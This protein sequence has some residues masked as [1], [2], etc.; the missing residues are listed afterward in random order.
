MSPG[1]DPSGR[2]QRVAAGEMVLP[3]QC[4]VC[5]K[6]YQ[7]E[8]FVDTKLDYDFYGVVYFCADCAFELTT[9]FPE[10]PYHAMRA[11]ILQLEELLVAKDA[12][13]KALNGAIDGLN[14]LA[15]IRTAD[16]YNPPSSVLSE[17]PVTA[18]EDADAIL[19]RLSEG[20]GSTDPEPTESVTVEGPVHSADSASSDEPDL[21]LDL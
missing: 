7:E 11:R 5:G 17:E 18:I 13:I 4:A 12:E 1:Y 19:A 16:S 3:A 2:F 8:G 14:T 6:T 9:V 21:L 15:A 10:A 20:S